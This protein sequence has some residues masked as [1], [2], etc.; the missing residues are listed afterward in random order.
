MSF[1]V[2]SGI[3][4]S[5]ASATRSKELIGDTARAFDGTF[6]QTAHDRKRSWQV[7][8]TAM[9]RTDANALETAL[10]STTLPLVCSGDL[11]GGTVNCYCPVVDS[12][13]AVKVNPHRAVVQFTLLEG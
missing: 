4:V 3:T 13:D 12:W 6:R 5:V 8:T 2:V 11:L 1:L 7:T 9:S 10:E